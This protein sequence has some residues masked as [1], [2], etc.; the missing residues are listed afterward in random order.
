MVGIK[1]FRL[2]LAHSR[3]TQPHR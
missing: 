1:Q 3:V 2:V